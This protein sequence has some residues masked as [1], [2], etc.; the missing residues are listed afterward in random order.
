MKK[1]K[2]IT[3][4]Q[5]LPIEKIYPN[6][7][8]KLK[9]N[10]FIKILRVNPINYNLKSDLEKSAILNAYKIFLKTCNFN[11]QILIQSNKENLKN[12]ISLINKNI[13]KNENNY[14]KNISD[15][16][17]DYI[18]NLNIINKA[19]SKD[20]YLIINYENKNKEKLELNDIIENNLKEKYFKIKE[21]LSRCGN[22]V[23]EILNSK[24]II[25]IYYSFLNTRKINK[26]NFIK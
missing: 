18:N 10:K 3:V 8:I 15:N 7:I 23:Q 24:E 1:I 11:I 9:K 4:Q 25:N 5:W 26:K 22:E 12:H 2:K 21:C 6:G 14:L 17:I 16:Y 19:S 20:F 13:Q